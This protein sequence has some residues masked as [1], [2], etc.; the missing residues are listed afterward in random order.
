M[1]KYLVVYGMELTVDMS[2][3]ATKDEGIFFDCSR[4]IEAS[5]CPLLRVLGVA[6]LLTRLS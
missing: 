3:V 1:T 5:I 4:G 6:L 2:Y